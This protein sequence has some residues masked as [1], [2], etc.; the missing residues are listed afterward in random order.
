MT[1]KD[2]LSE[3]V[4]QITT[5]LGPDVADMVYSLAKI[6]KELKV[7]CIEDIDSM[8]PHELYG[9]LVDKANIFI[10]ATSDDFEG[11]AALDALRDIQV[12]VILFLHNVR[13]VVL[14]D[15]EP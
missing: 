1:K 7:S 10:T 5:Q 11:A 2:S 13:K 3:Q 12:D 6:C 4:L 15:K 9:H 14:G 8:P